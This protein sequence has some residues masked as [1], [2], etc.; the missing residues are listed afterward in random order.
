MVLIYT[1]R[2]GHSVC[3]KMNRLFL[4]TILVTGLI[5]MGGVAGASNLT[6]NKTS[7]KDTYAPGE[8]ITW[9]LNL[10]NHN[11]T[12]ENDVKVL[13]RVPPT[14]SIKEYLIENGTVTND[15]WTVDVGPGMTETLKFNMS[16]N[17]SCVSRSIENIANITSPEPALD[18]H[19]EDNN[20]TKSVTITGKDCT[21]SNLSV[22][23]MVVGKNTY[24]L[25]EPITWIVEVTNH[26]TSVTVPVEITEQIPPGCSVRDYHPGEGE[27]NGDIWSLDL[28]PGETR[29]LTINATCARICGI[30]TITNIARIT[31]PSSALDENPADNSANSSV[32]I[33]GTACPN[34][35]ATMVRPKTLNLK[36]KGV[37]TVFFSLQGQLT[38][39]EDE[40][41]G[42]ETESTGARVDRENSR[43]ICNGAEAEKIL[44][45]LRD[46]GTIM[47]KFQRQELDLEVDN[48]TARLDCFGTVVLTDGRKVTIQGNDTIQVIHAEGPKQQSLIQRILA[49]FGFVSGN[50]DGENEDLT[51]SPGINLDEIKN[52]AQ[53]KKVLKNISTEDESESDDNEIT[54]VPTT[55]PGNGKPDNHGNGK[56]KKNTV[57]DQDKGKGKGN[58]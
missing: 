24:N 44:F 34:A 11:N 3:M 48:G 50:T 53:L 38:E 30:R 42:E 28:S 8:N 13:E 47:G 15:V 35:T 49:F 52:P 33:N 2:S 29:N 54:T 22:R 58:S 40:T 5:L 56:D 10:T 32:T 57:Q 4:M 27:M 45:S 46:G 55:R 43:L 12:Q 51:L 39:I 7:N 9:T 14:C 16:C 20:A 23:K 18:D 19:P 37:L 6:L 26:N 25:S 36:S 21:V 41:D 1:R 31:S 17:L